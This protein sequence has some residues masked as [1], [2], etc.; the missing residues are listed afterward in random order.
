MTKKKALGRSTAT[1]P[2][3]HQPGEGRCLDILRQLSAYIDDELASDICAEIRRHV[4]ACPNCE[5]FIASLRDTVKLCRH[6]ETP[7]LSAQDRARLRLDILR[8]SGAPGA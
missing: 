2:H 5:V 3:H 4:G 6:H 8:A 1:A 7:P